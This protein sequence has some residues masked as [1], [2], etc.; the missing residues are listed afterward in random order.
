MLHEALINHC[1][2]EEVVEILIKADPQ[3]AYYLNKEGKSPLYLAAEANYFHVVDATGKSEVEERMEN[4][5]RKAKPAVHGAILGKN[6]FVS[7][8]H[9]GCP[10]FQKLPLIINSL[11][12]WFLKIL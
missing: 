11:F 7:L 5:D 6:N 10:P 1:K 4:R 8:S 2:Q 9:V 12:N 3:V